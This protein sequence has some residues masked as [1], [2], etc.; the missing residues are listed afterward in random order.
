[1]QQ[2]LRIGKQQWRTNVIEIMHKKSFWECYVKA[3]NYLDSCKIWLIKDNASI[4]E[5]TLVEFSFLF[6]S[7]Q[8]KTP[9]ANLTEPL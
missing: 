8:R 3:T 2:N 5:T 4:V 1:M 6:V 9:L 7:S